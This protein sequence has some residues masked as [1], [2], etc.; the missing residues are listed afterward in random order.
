VNLNKVFSDV[1]EVT[2]M[3]S[4]CWHSVLPHY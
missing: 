1:S 2:A 3:Y 4:W